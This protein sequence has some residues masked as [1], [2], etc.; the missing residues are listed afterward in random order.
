[1]RKRQ[2]I[3]GLIYKATNIK[4][5]KVYIG[6]CESTLQKRIDS[7][8]SQAKRY[9]SLK[10]YFHNTLIKNPKNFIWEILEQDIISLKILNEREIYWI[11]YYKSNNK[12]F[13]YNLTKGGD[14]GSITLNHPNKKE[15]YKKSSETRKRNGKPV[16]SKGKN[17]LQHYIKKYGKNIGKKRYNEM[18]K[19]KGDKISKSKLG[20]KY[21]TQHCENISKSLKGIKPSEESIQKRIETTRKN[22]M[23]R[24][25]LPKQIVK[26][27]IKFYTID[28]FSLKKI[29]R[30]LK[31]IKPQYIRA[32]L[33]NNGITII[34]RRN[35]SK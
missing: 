2:F 16:W 23:L 18:M 17:I 27:I 25:K 35:G 22:T 15:I 3:T 34:Q 4:S 24:Y 26:Q 32:A 13:G 29:T 12:K 30:E 14:G 9:K 21:S 20:K 10:S 11:A 5:N 8:L 1:M 7:H 6:K 19:L 33:V 31:T 28:L